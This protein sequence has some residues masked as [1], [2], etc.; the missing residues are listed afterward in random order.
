MKQIHTKVFFFLK[1]LLFNVF[2][3][4]LLNLLIWNYI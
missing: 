3:W 1:T 2:A 4:N